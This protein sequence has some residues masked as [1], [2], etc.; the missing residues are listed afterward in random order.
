MNR[1]RYRLLERFVWLRHAWPFH[2]AHKPLC[3][4]FERDVKLRLPFRFGVI[5]V[6]EATQAVIRARVAFSDGRVAEGVAAETL[7][8]KWFDKNPGLSD[9]QNLDQ[10]RQAIDLAVKLY[11][12][13]GWSTAFGLY[14][15][16]YADEPFVRV[17]DEPPN[18]KDVRDTNFCD[19]TVRLV[20]AGE[21]TNIVVFAAI[22]NLIKGASGQ[23]I[24]NM[25]AV[26]ELEETC[27]LL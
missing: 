11:A 16:A 2:F 5:T 6:T 7:A 27:G 17:R 15:D 14:A 20:D 13:R 25:N 12:D 10:L 8:A 22:D 19:L 23:A 9:D 21:E 26:F 4:R 24:Q 18:V 3:E 1:L